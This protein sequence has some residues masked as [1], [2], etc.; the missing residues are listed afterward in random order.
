MCNPPLISHR[1]ISFLLTPGILAS[2]R[3]SAFGHM[4]CSSSLFELFCTLQLCFCCCRAE[5]QKLQGEILKRGRL[6]AEEKQ[7]RTGVRCNKCLFVTESHIQFSIQKISLQFYLAVF[8]PVNF[9]EHFGE[10]D[11]RVWPDIGCFIFY[12]FVNVICT[13]FEPD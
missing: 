11:R 9:K 3:G 12:I 1:Y 13:A 7:R 4:Q 2:V 6:R 5:L 8:F 10:N